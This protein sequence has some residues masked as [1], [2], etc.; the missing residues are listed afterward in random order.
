MYERLYDYQGSG[1]W[2]LGNKSLLPEKIQGYTAAWDKKGWLDIEYGAQGHYYKIGD[3]ISQ[4]Y[5]SASNSLQYVN[6][7]KVTSRGVSIE[8]KKEWGGYQARA[9]AE[10][11]NVIDDA[12]RW[13]DNSP[14][15]VIKGN[16]STQISAQWKLGMEWQYSSESMSNQVIAPGSQIGHMALTWE[17]AKKDLEIQASARNIFDKRER[18]PSGFD[19]SAPGRTSL[20]QEGRK[21]TI[22]GILKF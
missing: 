14:K 13:V 12:G 22:S 21:L 2:Q 16:L 3:M 9:S 4:S 10:W 11:R 17:S 20:P 8:G 1:T 19:P 6:L 18:L 15:V 5:D 7:S